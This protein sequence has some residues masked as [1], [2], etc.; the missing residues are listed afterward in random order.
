MAPGPP[1]KDPESEARGIT[2]CRVEYSTPLRLLGYGDVSRRR[3]PFAF[4]PLSEGA[5][6]SGASVEKQL[7]TLDPEGQPYKS[8]VI[9][10]ET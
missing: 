5:I 4:R 1:S 6:A 8:P 7:E 3:T 2:D 10:A 9:A